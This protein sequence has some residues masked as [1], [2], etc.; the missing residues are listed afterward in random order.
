MRSCLGFHSLSAYVKDRPEVVADNYL[1]KVVPCTFSLLFS[2]LLFSSF[3]FRSPLIHCLIWI[4]A[5]VLS[6]ED[7]WLPPKA[8]RNKADSY[9]RIGE[10]VD[11]TLIGLDQSQAQA[12][13]LPEKPPSLSWHKDTTGICSLSLSLSLFHFPFSFIDGLLRSPHTVLFSNLQGEADPDQG[14]ERSRCG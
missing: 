11:I 8:S 7:V 10:P 1:I 14:R 6:F 4:L 5:W 2:S 12:M 13:F 9:V 3:P